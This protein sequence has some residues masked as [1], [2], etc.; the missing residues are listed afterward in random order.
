M[1]F[2]IS[3]PMILFFPCIQYFVGLCVAEVITLCDWLWFY[4]FV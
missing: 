4:D 1:I 3:H 2:M